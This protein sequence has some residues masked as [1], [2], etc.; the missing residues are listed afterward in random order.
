[1]IW[2]LLVVSVSLGAA[3][4]IFMKL[5]MNRAGQMPMEALLDWREG[6][7][8]LWQHGQALLA[9]FWHALLVWQMLAAVI[10]YGVS[11]VLWLG[12]LSRADLTFARP[13]VS[14]GYILVILYGYYAGEALNWERLLGITLIV[15]GLV[16]VARSGIG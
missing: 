3:G 4:Q 1:M 16:F 11:Y 15:A 6:W 10:S 2:I 14:F 8:A 13:F 7:P 12:I 9:W 5:A